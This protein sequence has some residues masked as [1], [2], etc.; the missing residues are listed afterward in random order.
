MWINLITNALDAVR[1]VADPCI[2]LSVRALP[3]QQLEI[4]VEDNGPGIDPEV[5]EKIFEP[6]VTTKEI[7]EGTGLG[8]SIAYGA[9][10]SHAGQL[11]A[12]HSPAGGA[13][14]R[15]CLPL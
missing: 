8:L 11:T 1:D 7:G 14:F 3:D 4:R 15:I 10:Q 6:F 13:S 9:I 5:A 2:Q 12:T